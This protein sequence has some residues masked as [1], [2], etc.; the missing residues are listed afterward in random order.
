MLKIDGNSLTIQ[1]IR[2][3]AC[4]GKKVSLTGDARLAV[5]SS[6]DR[7]LK[8]LEIGKP[9]Y[10]INTGFGIFANK[11]ISP[12]DSKTLNRNLIISHTVGTGRELPQEIV[13][14]A[15]LIRA[16]ALAKGFSGI[17]LEIVETLIEML[18]RD[19]TPVVYDKGSLGSS[20]DLCMLAQMAMV[21]TRD[22]SDDEMD[23]GQAFFSG[24]KLP[25]HIAMR[26]AGLVRHVLSHKDGLALI[27]GA[28]FSAALLALCAHEMRLMCDLADMAASLSLEALFGRPDAFHPDLHK[29][30]GLVGQMESASNILRNISGSNMAG[31]YGQVQDAYSLRCAPQVHGAVRDSLRF[32]EDMIQREINAATDNPLIFGDDT[33]IS[34]GNFHGEPLGMFADFL[35]IALSELAAISERRV[36]RLLDS[37]LNNGLS[38][39][40]VDNIESE[41]LNSG[42]MMLQYTA[43]ALVLE[44]QTLAS[45][46]SVRSLPTSANQEDFNA[47][48]YLAAFHT[49]QV[50]ENVRKV[51]AIEIYSSCRGIEQRL[52]GNPEFGLGSG[53][54][55]MFS[56]IREHCPYH[57]GD[58]VWGEEID[59]LNDLFAEDEDFR[60]KFFQCIN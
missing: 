45:P 42:I 58:I 26:K 46:D 40:L 54:L 17:R 15:I 36:F 4:R 28:T 31:S 55:K 39:M 25:G 49:W 11:V 29:A 20:G 50:M 32:A 3:V 53:T 34:G 52:L 12:Q 43:A 2:D 35:T 22:E 47:N 8:I 41:G 1:E 60:E 23:S 16:N 37:S 59:K 30:R 27:N 5:S 24:E 13:R 38:Q 7:M 6:Y 33:V 14:A 9:V 19:I 48:A 57:A 56:L 18:N 21:L 51:L 10:G 44:N